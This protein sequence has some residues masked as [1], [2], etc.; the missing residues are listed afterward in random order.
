MENYDP[1]KCVKPDDFICLICIKKFKN[2]QGLRHHIS[3]FHLN[4]KELLDTP[5]KSKE[6]EKK[7]VD[8]LSDPLAQ[9]DENKDE[10]KKEEVN[11][12]EKK[13]EDRDPL[14]DKDPLDA[15]DKKDEEK[16]SK[17]EEKNGSTEVD[18]KESKG[19]SK[20]ETK[21]E[22][23]DSKGE[24]EDS[25]DELK[26]ESEKKDVSEVEKSEVE[27]SEEKPKENGIEATNGDSEAEKKPLADAPKKVDQDDDDEIMIIGEEKKVEVIKL[28]D[29]PSKMSP[30]DQALI[31]K[32][33]ELLK[34]Y[35]CEFC[36]QRF[37][38][39][40]NL[41]QH[42]R[43]HLKA[44]QKKE[45]EDPDYVRKKLKLNADGTPRSKE[46]KETKMGSVQK[47]DNETGPECFKCGQV[48]KDTA[49]LRNHV[50]SH[51]YRVFDPLIPQVKPFP[52]P[53][54]EKPSRDKITLIRHFAFTHNKVFELTEVTPANLLPGGV[55]VRKSRRTEGDTPKK[56]DREEESEA[57]EVQEE[58]KDEATAEPNGE[59]EAEKE[60]SERVKTPA[61][62]DDCKAPII[63][64]SSDESDDED[65]DP[66]TGRVRVRLDKDSTR[67][68]Y[69]WLNTH[70][71]VGRL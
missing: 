2:R 57:K 56:G 19:E 27:K 20:E 63:D 18:N 66:A 14:D 3:S 48:C 7:E 37:D 61:V 23:E 17:E 16:D 31:T 65:V 67:Y 70:L 44:H 59:A 24:K 43:T 30:R 22:K 34:K 9:N 69:A 21:E 60:D 35:G 49:N 62:V 11:K 54:C 29:T 51:Y 28:V 58:K 53:V 36:S 15:A 8:P 41:S 68:L 12:E 1:E 64:G 52:C 13:E 45:N 39:K 33:L 4:G 40:P 38:T 26:T 5:Q 47:H 25:K 32:M 10:K 42:E 6:G 71:Q 46:H 50:L 55:S